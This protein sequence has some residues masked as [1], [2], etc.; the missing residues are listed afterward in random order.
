MRAVARIAQV[1][2]QP[3]PQFSDARRSVAGLG[4]DLGEAIPRQRWHEDVEGV[5]GIAAVGAGIG[6]R[7]DDLVEFVESAG[8]AVGEHERQGIGSLP[9]CVDVVQA[10]AVDLAHEMVV[11]VECGLL[12][13]PVEAVGPVSAQLLKVGPVRSV[14]PV[15]TFDLGG[16]ARALETL[17]QV[18]QRRVRD[19]YL[20]RRCSHLILRCPPLSLQ[21]V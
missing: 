21:I 2:E 3:I 12:T 9:G 7:F 20:E 5:R 4:W 11:T 16:P 19:L 15:A 14:G 18:C 1:R 17:T 6:Q 13:A 10:E 8:P